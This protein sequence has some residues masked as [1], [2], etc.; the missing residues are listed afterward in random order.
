MNLE[1]FEA[2]VGKDNLEKIK[3]LNILIVGIGGVGGYTFES[4]EFRVEIGYARGAGIFLY[5]AV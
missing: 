1:R 2:L 3:N 4:L 5:G